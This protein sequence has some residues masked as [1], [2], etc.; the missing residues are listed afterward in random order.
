[1]NAGKSIFSQLMDFLPAL[2]FR[3]CVERYKGDHKLQRFSCWDQFLCMAFAQLTYRESLRDIEAC[4]LAQQSKLYHGA[5]SARRSRFSSTRLG[6]PCRA[7]RIIARPSSSVLITAPGA[8]AH[9][10]GRSGR[11]TA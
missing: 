3:Q 5:P 2:E 8:T 1:M 4:L 11:K 10:S 9:N 6:A 7:A